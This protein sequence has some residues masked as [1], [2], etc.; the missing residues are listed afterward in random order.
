M[1]DKGYNLLLLPE[2]R[3]NIVPGSFKNEK[4]S[5][6]GATPKLTSSARESSSLPIGEYA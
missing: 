5:K 3:E 4:T 2:S 6:E 1:P